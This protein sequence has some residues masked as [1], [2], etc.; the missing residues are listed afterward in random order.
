MPVRVT[1]KQGAACNCIA[2]ENN[3]KN[4]VNRVAFFTLSP[5]SSQHGSKLRDMCNDVNFALKGFERERDG[6]GTTPFKRGVEFLGS[7]QLTLSLQ[8]KL[9]ELLV[10]NRQVTTPSRFKARVV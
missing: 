6:I 2:H 4:E 7:R 5:L 9:L 1:C 10:R 3:K 8:E